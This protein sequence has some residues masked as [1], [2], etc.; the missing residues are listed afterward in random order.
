MENIKK[1]GNTPLSISVYSVENTATRMHKKGTLEIIFCL[2]GSV[3]FAYYYEEFTL[4][5]GEYISVDKDAYYLFDGKDNIC[6]SFYID[7]C[8]YNTKYPF[9]QSIFFVCEGLEENIKKYPAEKHNIL[10]GKLIA[11]MK[12]IVN[13][14]DYET[15]DKMTGKIVDLFVHTFDMFF[16]HNMDF[17]V[18]LNTLERVH[19]IYYWLDV[20]MKERVKLSDLAEELGLSETYLSKYISR[21]ALG[22]REMLAYMRANESERYLLFSD[23]N[24]MEISEECGFSD[25]KYYYEAFKKWYG[26]T[27]KQFRVNYTRTLEEKIT[28]MEID[29]IDGLLNCALKQHYMDIFLE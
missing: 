20:H 13:N 4:H 12:H 28:Y 6:V 26:C 5:A 21:L 3:K 24:I 25:V 18:N 29:D 17:D 11:L 22:F 14:G 2:K 23:K 27:P 1:I 10:K 16:Y 7:L 19:H 8:R 9:I 15:I